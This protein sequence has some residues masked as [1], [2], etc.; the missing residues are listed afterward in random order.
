MLVRIDLLLVLNEG[1]DLVG[2]KVVDFGQADAV[3]AGNHAAEV[4]REPHN[5]ID[6]AVGLMQHAV[7]IRVHRD[8]GVYVTVTGMHVQRHEQAII[9]QCEV[10][11]S[12]C[13]AQRLHFLS[14]EDF[15]QML[16][17]LIA[18]GHAHV[19]A[20]H[21][22]QQAIIGTDRVLFC[23]AENVSVCARGIVHALQQARPARS[24]SRQMFPREIEL[25]L[26]NRAAFIAGLVVVGLAKLL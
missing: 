11:R 22:I 3:L 14:A 12:Q 23:F 4:D 8:I 5:S 2:A 26:E 18:I 24:H 6:H 10:F 16:L 19:A 21:Q 17:D 7:I 9:L 20:Q 15:T 1:V 25:G 13:V